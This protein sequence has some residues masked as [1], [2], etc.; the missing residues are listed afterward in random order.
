MKWFFSDN[1]MLEDVT[2]PAF[3]ITRY[4]FGRDGKGHPPYGPMGSAVHNALYRH[5]DGQGIEIVLDILNAE[6]DSIIKPGTIP[7]GYDGREAKP[8]FKQNVFDNVEVFCNEHPV[9][10]L[11]YRVIEQ[12]KTIGVDMGNGY[13]FWMKRDMLIQEMISGMLVPFDHKTR[14]GKINKWWCDKFR[15]CSQ[16]SGY[17]WGTKQHAK[18]KGQVVANKIYVNAISMQ[19]LPTD[20]KKCHVHDMPYCECRKMHV[21]YELMTFGRSPAAL[22]AWRNAVMVKMQEAKSYTVAYEGTGVDMLKHVPRLG[23][24]RDKCTFCTLKRWCDL[25]F[26]PY[27]MDEVTVPYQWAPWEDKEREIVKES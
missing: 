22:K 10:S 9:H 11:P 1:S 19:A 4:V 8:L 25:D 7:M 5:Y 14:W 15:N 3:Y 16:F 12:E 17:I 21:E 2:C 13:V 24:F 23:M 27:V 26:D 6:Y 20:T 18:K